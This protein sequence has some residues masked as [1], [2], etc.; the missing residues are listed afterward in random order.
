MPVINGRPK[1]GT[2]S[3][4]VGNIMQKAQ[5]KMKESAALSLPCADSVCA[6]AFRHRPRI[7]LLSNPKSTGNLAQLSR[8]R[9]YCADHPDVF[10]YEVEHVDQ[11]GNALK[12]IARVRPKMLV[13]N[14][15]DGTVQA[16]LTEIHNG[17]HFGDEPPPMAVL[18]SGKTNLIAL[19]LGSHGDPIVAL[20][21]LIELAQGDLTPHLTPRKLIALQKDGTER[22]VIGMFLG[23]AGLA[24]I[25]LYCRNTIYPLGLP[26]GLSHV[27]AALALVFR[28]VFGLR[29]KF[30]PPNP[31]PLQLSTN[32]DSQLSGRFALLVVTTLDKILLS[33]D[34]ETTGSG[35]LRMLALEERP[36]SV[37]RAF[38]AGVLGKLWSSKFRGIHVEETDE[39]SIESENSDV[40]L[41]GEIFRAETGR[42]IR[43]KPAQPLSFVRLAA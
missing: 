26:N 39:I 36:A 41:D 12:T 6:S 18:P 9:D 25:M 38:A 23:G 42:A 34:V 8:I 32:R 3:D 20:G 33:G 28:S 14:G 29:A 15:G 10:H 40:I 35:P 37:I 31:V 4:P 43:L 22:P 11:I 16:A 1:G 21:R 7:A 2:H 17:G 5:L 19:D 30:L 24:D 13:I 27:L